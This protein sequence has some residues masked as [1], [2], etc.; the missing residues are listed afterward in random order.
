VQPTGEPAPETTD[1]TDT[2]A[3]TGGAETSGGGPGSS[4][5]VPPKLDVGAPDP[6][7]GMSSGC[8]KA[9]FL[10][11]ID[12][13]ASMSDEQQQL[14]D[15]F[16][17]F[18]NTIQNTLAAQ[19]YHIMVV[20]TDAANADG[21]GSLNCSNG[22]CTC[23][24]APT[25]CEGVCSMGNVSCN[26]VACDALQSDPCDTTLGGGKQFD[27][28]GMLCLPDDGPRYMTEQ[29]ADLTATFGCVAAVGITGSG[30][31]KPMEAMLAAAG[32]GLNDDGACNAGFVRED[33]ILVVTFITDE[34]DGVGQSLGDPDSW[35][36]DLIEIKSGDPEA[37]VVLG[38]IGDNDQPNK[39]CEELDPM[40]GTVGAQAA[41]RLRNFVSLF[42]DR[43][44]V[45]SVCS[46]SYS[47]FFVD[48]VD[49]IDLA[50]DEFMPPG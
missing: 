31:E 12:N 42:G 30:M 10:F 43:G 41:P 39:I 4:G 24:P 33:A 40:V 28:D 8:Q 21:G 11:V 29:Q 9:D 20:D 22:A 34:E 19:D 25:C 27:K 48:A 35:Y 13:S 17:E 18:I 16:P 14:I 38:L 3:P 26:G 49:I 1:T 44:V 2:G 7:G 45:G 15:S 37:L 36:A 6:T 5:D 50:C 46:P 47:P 23:T 32:P